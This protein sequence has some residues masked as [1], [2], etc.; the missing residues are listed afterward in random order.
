LIDQ[1]AAATMALPAVVIPPSTV[2][3]HDA[4]SASIDD[5]SIRVHSPPIII[6]VSVAILIKWVHS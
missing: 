1:P 5:G 2:D 3:H 4:A 6:Q